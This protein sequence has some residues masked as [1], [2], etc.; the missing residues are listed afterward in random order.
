MTQAVLINRGE[1]L[2]AQQ[3]AALR[4]SHDEDV[5]LAIPNETC[6]RPAW[7]DKGERVFGR[8]QSGRPARLHTMRPASWFCRRREAGHAVSLAGR[9]PE[10]SLRMRPMTLIG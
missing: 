5:G 2:V 4:K 9:K 3:D 6:G 7:I 8:K 1:N 10:N